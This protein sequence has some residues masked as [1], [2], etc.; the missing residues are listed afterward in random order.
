MRYR[1]LACVVPVI[2]IVVLA[3]VRVASQAPAPQQGAAATTWTPPRTADGH[4]DLQGLWSNVTTTPLERP[5]EYADREFLTDEE[6]AK[7]LAAAVERYEESVSGSGYSPDLDPSPRSIDAQAYNAIFYE[8]KGKP[9]RRTSLIID[10]PDG[11]IPP[12]KPEAQMR[13]EAWERAKGVTDF[14]LGGKD[15]QYTLHSMSQQTAGSRADNPEDRMLR[16]RCL[17]FGFPRMP[18]GYNNNFEIVQH[19]KFVVIEMEM[20]HEARV[21]PLDGRS[22]LPSDVRQLLGDSRGRWD[23]DTLVIDTTNFT[24]RAPF[25]GSFEGLHVVERLTRVDADT[26]NYE[27]AIDDLTAFT[28]PWSLAF[29]LTK[30]QDQVPLMF[31]YACHEGNY[32]L[33]GQLSAARAEDRSGRKKRTR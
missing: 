4:P 28:K 31:E 25:R 3:L 18:G 6:Y 2:S 17:T 27:L 10:P 7:E 20:A 9:L 32:G 14:R 23:G 11:K 12:L 13:F 8:R 24:D 16:E 15:R 1:L 5:A 29:P 33:E 26:I 19:S 30:L 22:H 21:I